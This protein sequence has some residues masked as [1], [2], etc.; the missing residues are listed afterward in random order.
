MKDE[1]TEEDKGRKSENTEQIPLLL[2]SSIS[3]S[4]FIIHNSS[5]L[6]S[7]SHVC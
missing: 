7:H 4:L 6:I 3:P 1:V 5:F 2:R